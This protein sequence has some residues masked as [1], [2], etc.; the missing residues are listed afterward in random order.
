[1]LR[2][3]NFGFNSET[4]V[5]NSFQHNINENENIIKDKAKYEFDEMVKTLEFNDISV[6]VFKDKIEILPDSVFMNNWVSIFPDGKLVTYPILNNIRRKEKRNDIVNQIIEKFDITEY[7]DLSDYEKD[8]IF[9]EGTGSVVFDFK[10][11][12]AFACL[13]ERTSETVFN[14]LCEKLGYKGFVFSATSLDGMPIY[15][16]NVMMSIANKYV[17]ICS[18]SINDPLERSIIVNTLKSAGKQIIELSHAQLNQFAGN[19]FE[20]VDSNENSKLVM[21]RTAH[22]SLTD[23]QKNKIEQYS[24][25]ISVNI[26][27]IERVGG[28]SARCMLTGVNC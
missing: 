17:L 5:T 25:I 18:D 20:V 24:D 11:K 19:S 2:P 4:K 28:G 26:S 3:N 16:T 15:H 13:S 21:S 22:S 27:I 10:N 12:L 9:L 8:N 14:I 1:M 23:S 6:N 7:I